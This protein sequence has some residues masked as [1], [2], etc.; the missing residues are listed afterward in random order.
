MEDSH[1]GRAFEEKP[2]LSCARIHLSA[3]TIPQCLCHFSSA[4]FGGKFDAVV[5]S[6]K[7]AP[8]AIHAMLE[9]QFSLTLVHARRPVERL[10]LEPTSQTAQPLPTVS[11]KP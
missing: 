4:I 7:G 10:I 3:H 11:A 1:S 5:D 8:E 9:Q 6:W 2:F